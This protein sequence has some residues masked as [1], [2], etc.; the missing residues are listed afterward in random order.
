MAENLSAYRVLRRL[1]QDE[2]AARMTGLG[3]QMS[4]STISGIESLSRSVTVDELL[5]LAICMG[6]TIGQLLDATG[7][8]HSRPY[9]LDV[10]LRAS[11]GSARLLTPWVA[12]LLAASRAC[13]RLANE[14][15]TEI[16]MQRAGRLPAAARR[17][18]NDMQPSPLD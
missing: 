6:V 10:G 14:G 11:D 17:E 3:H 12:H 1:T 5:G 8:E 15:G 18:L 13:L 4:R 2:L 16:E 9:G 7:P